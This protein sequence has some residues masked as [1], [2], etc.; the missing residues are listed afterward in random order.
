MEVEK[1]K[2]GIE[3]SEELLEHARDIRPRDKI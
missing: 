1:G 2:D 3:K